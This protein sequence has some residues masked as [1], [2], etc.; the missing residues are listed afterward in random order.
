MYKMRI[1]L[2]LKY[3]ISTSIILVIVLGIT[4]G[5]LAKRHKELVIAQ[6]E[7]QAKS[8]FSQIVITRRWVADHGGVFVEK[9]PWVKPNPYLNNQL[10]LDTAGKQYVK[11]NPAM[12]TKQLSAYAQKE[13]LYFFHITSLKLL[14]PDN[15]PD[16][17]ERRALIDFEARRLNESSKIEK[18]GASHYF[19]YI[20]PLYVEGSCLQCHS[21]QGYRIGDIRGAISVSVPMGYA[22]NIIGA[23]RKYMIFG[24]FAAVTV[25]MAVLFLATRHMVIIPINK[26]RTLMFKFSKSGEAEATVLKTGDEIEDL[27]R[28]FADMAR[29]IDGHHKDLREKI[30]SATRE[31]IEKNESLLKLNKTKSDF[32]AKISHE[33]RT[34]LTSIKGA[35]DY[36]S[37]RLPMRV[38]GGEEDLIV[39]F[40]MIRKNS[41]RLIRLV[42]NVLD[43][44]RIGLGKF[45]MHFNEVNL[46]DGFNEVI[47]GFKSLAEEKGVTI[48]LKGKDV[49]ACADEDRI[50]QVLINLLSNA[51][52][53]SPESSEILVSLDEADGYVHVSVEDRGRGIPESERET[54]FRQFYS[55][56]VKDGTGLGLAICKGIIETHNGEIGVRSASGGGSCFYFR[57]PKDRREMMPDE[58][59]FACSR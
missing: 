51:L 22:F 52:N 26:I 30:E 19:R 25:L 35:M 48:R 3:I 6:T 44:E 50:K 4:L 27:S 31:L 46:R 8:L 49:T 42:N 59:T 40:E 28:A 23:D 58:K 16:E 41:E 17:F 56:G 24:G 12:V 1:N 39:F 21:K 45:E 29:S 13:G 7:L 34:P 14:N 10:I 38:K 2:G 20:A 47:T 11:E 18:I 55:A 43:Y 9:L 33:L 53:F 37:V 5:I 54:I 32:I 57:I 15:A 36:L